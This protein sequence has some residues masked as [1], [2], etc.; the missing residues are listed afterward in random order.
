MATISTDK[1]NKRESGANIAQKNHGDAVVGA[2]GENN[3]TDANDMDIDGNVVGTS[4]AAEQESDAVKTA[5]VAP[6]N[7]RPSTA[8]SVRATRTPSAN[9]VRQQGRRARQPPE[10][11]RGGGS[12]SAHFASDEG[13]LRFCAGGGIMCEGGSAEF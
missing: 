1:G 3:A 2:S 4:V 7:A 13:A 11:G 12:G 6:L 8:L 9:P 5:R 10:S